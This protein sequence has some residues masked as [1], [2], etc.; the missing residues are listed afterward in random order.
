MFQL[1]VLLIIIDSINT[2]TNTECKE[3]QHTTA[4]KSCK[5][6]G[7]PLSSL[8]ISETFIGNDDPCYPVDNTGYRQL[9]TNKDV[10][11]QQG[12]DVEHIIDISN[13]ID[14]YL[15]ILGNMVLSNSSWNRGIGNFCWDNVK[16]EKEE[17]YG[18]LFTKAYEN[19]VECKRRGQKD[20][21]KIA[22]LDNNL[23]IYIVCA[24]LI[25]TIIIITIAY[26]RINMSQSDSTTQSSTGD[27][28]TEIDDININDR[29]ISDKSLYQM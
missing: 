6:D 24:M 29:T 23:L 12:F 15:Y 8:F 2:A 9:L 26:T 18:D 13:S 14:G 21:M 28:F 17:V 4:Y 1:I 27:L 10:N 20:N 22:L 5:E 7:R 11:Q 3:D 19:V 16:K 25:M